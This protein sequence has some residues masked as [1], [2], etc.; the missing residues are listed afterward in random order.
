MA[1]V[2]N[3]RGTW[4][5]SR[6]FSRSCADH[7]AIPAAEPS[8]NGALLGERPTIVGNVRRPQSRRQRA[9]VETEIL[10]ESAENR[11]RLISGGTA[12]GAGSHRRVP[13]GLAEMSDDPVG[14]V[15]RRLDEVSATSF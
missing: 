12:F 5:V 6:K 7:S 11:L 14:H 10:K 13:P 2:S 3:R 15:R 9:R 4:L 1:R 8:G